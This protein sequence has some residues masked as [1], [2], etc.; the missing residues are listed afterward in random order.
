MIEAD[1]PLPTLQIMR[2]W[3]HLPRSY[4]ATLGD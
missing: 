2:G 3:K 4:L 1:V